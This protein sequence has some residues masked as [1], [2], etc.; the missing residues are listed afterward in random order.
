MLVFYMSQSLRE[1]E[2][3]HTNNNCSAAVAV[4]ISDSAGDQEEEGLEI[5][6]VI[7]DDAFTDDDACKHPSIASLLPA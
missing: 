5:S 6:N 4:F 3:V 1:E 7:T 2:R